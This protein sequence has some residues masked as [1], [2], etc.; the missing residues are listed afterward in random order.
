VKHPRRDGVV[1]FATDSRENLDRW[2]KAFQAGSSIEVQ[3][4]RTVEQIRITDLEMQ[5]KF[6]SLEANALIDHTPSPS[7]MMDVC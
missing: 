2:I 4:V 5:K 7:P 3:S 1:T 6:V